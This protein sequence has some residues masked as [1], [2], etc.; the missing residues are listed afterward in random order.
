MQSN[1]GGSTWTDISL[2]LP[3]TNLWRLDIHPYTGEVALNS[4]MGEYWLQTPSDYP[5]LTHKNRHTNFLKSF[6]DLDSIP[7]PIFLSV[8]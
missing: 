8:D 5:S 7:H 1:N 6:Y 4:S 2:N 3:H